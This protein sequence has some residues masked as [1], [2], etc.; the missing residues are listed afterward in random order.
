MK[1]ICF[2]KNTMGIESNNAVVVAEYRLL[3]ACF[4][5]PN[6][7]NEQD[8]NEDIFLHPQCK[9]ILQALVELKKEGIEINENSLYQRVA[10]KDLNVT[11]SQIQTLI[12]INEDANVQIKDI[13]NALQSAKKVEAATAKLKEA[14]Q[15]LSKNLIMS[16]QD[17]EAFRDAIADAETQMLQEDNKMGLLTFEQWTDSYLD[18]F[19]QRKNGKMY[20]FND[21]ILDKLITTGPEPGNG[22]LICASPGMGKSSYVLNL[23]NRLIDRQIACIYFSLEMGKMN[24]MDRLMSIR[25]QIPFKNFV[26]PTSAEV[27][28]ELLG[29]INAEREKLLNCDKFRFCEDPSLS[30]NDIKSYIQ[31]FQADTGQNYCIVVIDLITMVKDFTSTKNGVNLAASMEFAINKMNAIAKELNIHWIGVAQLNRTVE[32]E[33]IVDIDDIYKYRPTRNAVKNANALL[34]RSRYLLSLFR[35]KYY[36]EMY[37][38]DEQDT[39]DLADV[40]EIGLLKQSNGVV[41]R[42]VAL[43]DGETFTISPMEIENATEE[44]V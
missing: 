39:K 11:Q 22:G 37:L 36:A 26:N 20:F 16:E 1:N 38:P 31:K 9:S 42:E 30:L 5:N 43:F 2:S 28:D 35:P 33:K 13:V 10:A 44:S 24:T 29:Y 15:L 7:L 21:P 25:L 6:N 32:S 41:G 14:Q 34:E 12:D 18:E 4:V 40:I 3:N 8:V 23:I 17:K 27:H 19:K